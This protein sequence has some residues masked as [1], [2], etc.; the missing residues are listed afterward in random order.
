MKTSAFLSILD[1][2]NKLSVPNKTNYPYQM[3]IHCFAD[4]SEVACGPCIYLRSIVVD[5]KRR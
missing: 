2:V 5:V 3:E 1:G 4:T